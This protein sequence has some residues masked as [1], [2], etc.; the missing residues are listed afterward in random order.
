VE[1]ADTVATDNG[2][3]RH[4]VIEHII[5]EHGECLFHAVCT[6]LIEEDFSDF[7]SVCRTLLLA[8]KRSEMKDAADRPADNH[9]QTI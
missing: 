4:I 8:F 5:G 6:P 7:K 9:S 1:L 3:E 2:R